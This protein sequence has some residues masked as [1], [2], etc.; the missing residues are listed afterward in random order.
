MTWQTCASL[1]VNDQYFGLEP[2]T[3]GI[4]TTCR[5][6]S[7]PFEWDSTPVAQTTCS[8]VCAGDAAQYC[9]APNYLILFQNRLYVA[10]T[11][12]TSAPP[13]DST[14]AP[15]A[16]T[17]SSAPPAPAE[18]SSAPPAETSSAPPAETSSAG[19]ANPTSAPP[20]ETSSEPPTET[21]T[22]PPAE[23]SVA[24]TPSVRPNF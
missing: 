15:P 16:D 3:D 12:T 2:V 7:G 4:S 21:T 17:T 13:A 23:T 11:S 9:G 1:C 24:A 18:T 19:P 14:S 10:P 22:Q 5:C 6:G 8:S 20:V